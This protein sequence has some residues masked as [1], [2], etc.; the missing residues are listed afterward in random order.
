MCC[1]VVHAGVGPL[2]FWGCSYGGRMAIQ[3]GVRLPYGRSGGGAARG[4]V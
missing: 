2:A 3:G 1:F 4:A